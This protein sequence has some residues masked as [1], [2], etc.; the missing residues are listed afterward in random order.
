MFVFL[1]LDLQLSRKTTLRTL[2]S[3]CQTFA[4]NNDRQYP[5]QDP[6]TPFQYR[7]QESSLDILQVLFVV[8]GLV[9]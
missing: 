7:A 9:E 8:I 4:Y 6:R 5:Q 2:L 1:N 3:Q